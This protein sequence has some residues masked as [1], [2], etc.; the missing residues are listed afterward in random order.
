[1]STYQT[2]LYAVGQTVAT[3]R[4]NRVERRNAL[5]SA[6]LGELLD[7][8]NR[9]ADDP[10]VRAIL[11][12]AEGPTFS[13]GQDLSIFTGKLARRPGAAGGHPVL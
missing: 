5:T 4:L 6:L 1:M 7:A 12:A 3:I 2:I 13:A 10:Q 9:A 8:M 11:L